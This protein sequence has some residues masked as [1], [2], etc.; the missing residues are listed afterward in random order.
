MRLGMS[1]SASSRTTVSVPRKYQMNLFFFAR[2]GQYKK[3]DSFCLSSDLMEQYWVSA[4]Q[5]LGSLEFLQ[6]IDQKKVRDEVN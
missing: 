2:L 3:N 1:R 6:I 4:F 5:K